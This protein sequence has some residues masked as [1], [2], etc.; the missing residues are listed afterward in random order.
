MLHFERVRVEEMFLQIIP[1]WQVM[2]NNQDSMS[3]LC[4]GACHLVIRHSHFSRMNFMNVYFDQR[5]HFLQQGNPVKFHEFIIG[6][7]QYTCIST[8]IGLNCS[9]RLVTRRNMTVDNLH[10]QCGFKAR[11]KWIDWVNSW[12]APAELLTKHSITLNNFW[13]AHISI[14]TSWT[15]H[16]WK[17]ILPISKS[18]VVKHTLT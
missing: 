1:S 6:T 15:L 12:R 3:T 8:N 4:F 11:A 10:V 5:M 17:S 13:R 18:I 16:K 7:I 9:S 2:H 14:K